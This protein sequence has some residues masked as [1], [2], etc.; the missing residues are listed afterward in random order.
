M[1][2]SFRQDCSWYN[3]NPN[4]GFKRGLNSILFKLC[5]TF[6]P[7][8][9]QVWGPDTSVADIFDAVETAIHDADLV[10]QASLRIL[11]WGDCW[12]CLFIRL[13]AHWPTLNFN[14]E[15]SD[16]SKDLSTLF[17]DTMLILWYKI[18]KTNAFKSFF[19]FFRTHYGVSEQDKREGQI[20]RD[21]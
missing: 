6:N 20:K 9:S 8:Y 16:N 7:N 18:T 15:M 3:E 10:P 14:Y 11:Q 17:R 1:E 21:Q 2:T 19:I 12:L 4:F 13:R 5:L